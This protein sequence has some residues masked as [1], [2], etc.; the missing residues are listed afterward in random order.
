MG[1][2]LIWELEERQAF[3]PF[4]KNFECI[5]TRFIMSFYVFSLSRVYTYITYTH[6][7]FVTSLYIRSYIRLYLHTF[8]RYRYVY[9]YVYMYVH[10][11]VY[12][13][14]TK[15][16]KRNIINTLMYFYLKNFVATTNYISS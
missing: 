8:I 16:E 6:I 15:E 9:M 2:L 7:Y 11:Y 10:A 5:A 14:I 4:S 13:Y 1:I 3:P 12:T